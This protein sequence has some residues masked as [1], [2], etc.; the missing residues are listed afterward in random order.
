MEKGRKNYYKICRETAGLTQEAASERLHIASRSL[1]DYERDKVIP[2][3]EIVMKMVKIYN[4]KMLGWWHLRNN[5]PLAK[6][7]LPEFQIPQSNADVYLQIDF[8]EDD[9][10]YIKSLIK[11]I[12]KDGKLTQDEVENYTEL[13]EKAKLIAGKMMSIYAFEPIVEVSNI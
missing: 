4:S 2:D 12:L 1:S 13:R 9:I 8:S 3:D 6:E 7:C 10:H 11:K 5:S